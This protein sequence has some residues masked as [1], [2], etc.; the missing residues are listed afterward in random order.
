V[1]FAAKQKPHRPGIAT[2]L[3]LRAGTG[4]RSLIPQAVPLK[5][6][7]LMWPTLL[8][9]WRTLSGK[10]PRKGGP[11]RRPACRRLCLEAL[12]DR[13]VPASL[14]YSTY[15]HGTVQAI[16]ADS[17]GDIYVTGSTDSSLPTTPGA[18]QT[19]GA[20]RSWRS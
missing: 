9:L 13:A 18:F 20:G 14:G 11:R 15:L 7:L 1:R 17:T 5:E 6:I 4:N 3:G 8:T 2:A 19:S 10:P 16:A 12:E